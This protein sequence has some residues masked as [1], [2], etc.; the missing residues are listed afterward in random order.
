MLLPICALLQFAINDLSRGKISIGDQFAAGA[1]AA[2]MKTIEEI[3]AILAG[4]SLKISGKKREALGEKSRPP[5]LSR[6]APG[7]R[8]ALI[9]ATRRR[10]EPT[11]RIT[12]CR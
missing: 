10:L 4:E 6:L 3:D 9:G 11:K 2:V 8:R 7:T 12:W 1:S 5:S